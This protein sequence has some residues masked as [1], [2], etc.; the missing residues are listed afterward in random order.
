MNTKK[1]LLFFL[2]FAFIGIYYYLIEIKK[3]EKTKEIDK[4]KKRVFTPVKK[5][6]IFEVILE[7][8]NEK[9]IRLARE[10]GAWKIKE[11]VEADTDK[12]SADIWIDYVAKLTKERIIAD[13]VKNK[14]E[15]GLDN[16]PFTVHV[17]TA[18][19]SPMILELGDEI[20]TGSMFYS[21]LKKKDNVF[22]IAA[23]NKKGIVKSAYEL[24]DKKIFHF[25][26]DAVEEI[27]VTA[28]GGNYSV[29]KKDGTW[30]VAKPKIA[31]ADGEKIT[32]LLQK[33]RIATIKKFV[34][35]EAEDLTPYGL[36]EPHTQITFLT[37]KDKA[38]LVLT[39]G[40]ENADDEGIYAKTTSN[41]KVFLLKKEFLNDFPYHVNNIRDKSVLRFD[42]E[43]VNKIQFIFPDKAITAARNNENNWEIIEPKK[44]RADNFEINSLLDQVISGKVKDF[45]PNKEKQKDIF[46]LKNPR[47]TVKLFVKNDNKPE[48]ISF[49]ADNQPGKTVYAN[50]GSLDEVLLIDH[51]LFSKLNITEIS[52]QHKY[53]LALEEDKI[54]HI[55]IK[56]K[57]KEYFLSNTNNEWALDKPEKKKLEPITVKEI[58][59]SLGNIKFTDIL[60]EGE[61]KDL[62]AFGLQNPALKVN[63][64]DDKKNIIESLL[65][66]AKTKDADSLFGM[67]E[68]S[69]TIYSIESR[70]KDELLDNIKILENKDDK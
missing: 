21:K 12:D 46:A 29:E 57:G 36:K 50:T 43:L 60:D 40:K 7:K 47:L 59:W 53:L 49:G 26:N 70:L 10:N 28:A 2:I 32:S 41:N 34:A 69:K 3:V 5:E 24:R 27:K 11:P 16:P 48:T 66:S 44:A 61:K 22:L 64:L 18:E 52:L 30:Q 23:Y 62:T 56:T 63:L 38:P 68:K 20:P 1:T 15:F 6:E 35:E 13:S 4:E 51:D 39:I 58:I 33:T 37:G 67:T 65:L 19:G 9:R 8:E 14:A 25:E 17:K 45:I 54:A 31:L 55:Q 42:K